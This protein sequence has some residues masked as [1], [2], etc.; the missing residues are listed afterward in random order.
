[1]IR[2]LI[3]YALNNRFIVLALGTLLLVWGAIS[4]HN[5]PV[6]AY[7]DV[8]NNYVQIITQW[9][10]RAAEEVEQQVT[11]PIETQVNGIPHLQ[12][13]RSVSLFG[14][15]SV[16]M[17]FDDVSENDW[18]RQKVLERLSQVTLPNGLQP[19][20]GTDWSP[21]GQIYWYTLKS[22]NPKYDL[23]ELKS[24]QDWVLEKQFKSVPNVVDVVG[25][26]GTTREYQVRVDPNKLVAYG[27]SIGQVE[28][29]LANNNTNA[30]GSFVEAGLQQV[31]VREVGLLKSTRDIAET[32]VK[33]QNGIAI[34]VKDIAEVTQAPKIRL[35]QIGKTIRRDNG[36][37]LDNEDVIEGIVLLR[38]GANA[39]I[40]LVAIHEKVKELNNQ[41]LPSGVKIVPFLDR[42]NLVHLTTHTVLHNLTE[43]VLLVSV[44][45]F[46]FLGN[47]R[48]AVIVALTIPFSLLFAAICLDLS[49]IPANLLSLGALDFGMVVDGT[50]VII[51][52]I[53]RHFSLPESAKKT[54]LERIRDAVR[55][56][57]RPVF[58]ARAIIIA[59][60]LP[61]FTL[62]SV[63]GRLFKPMAWTVSF[64]LVGALIF[65]ILIAP[66][67]AFLQFR[68][69]VNEWRN[70]VMQFLKD[71]YRIAVKWAIEHRHITVGVG[72]GA[73]AVAVFLLVSGVIGS[74]F[75]PH[76]D[77]G[78]IWVR[79]TL[80]PSTGPTEGVR[81]A[82]QARVILAS[83]PEVQVTTSQVGRPDD[84][85]DTTGFFNTEFFVDLK[86]KEKWRP[87]FREN[88]DKLIAA[89]DRELTKIPGV[90][91]NFSQPI[92]DNMEEAVSGV[93][94]ELAVKLYGEDLK[95]LEKKGD[96]IVNIMRGISG[97][98]DLGLFRVLGQPNLNITVDRQQAARHGINVADVQDAVETSVG[99]KAVSQ[100]L[101]NEQRFDLVVRY[102]APYRETRQAI[103]NVRLLS[104]TGER[105]SLGQFA[106]LTVRDGASEIYREENSR[107]VAI[108]YSV[109]GR[110]LGS[111][112][113]DAMKRVSDQVKLPAGYHLNWSGEYESQ[114]R[115]EKRLLVV[116]PI[117]ILGIFVILYTMFGSS[118]W[119][120]LILANVA[121]APIGGLLALLIT[122]THLS[123]SSGV[124]FL[125]L[126]GVSVE[127]GVIM[128]EY[129]NQ[130]RSAGHTIESA[131][132]E[133]AVL[134][135]RPIM[136]TMLVAT[137]GLFPAALSRAIGSD[138]QRPFAI[139]IVGGLIGALLLSIFLL[140]ALYVWFAREGDRLPE[141]EGDFLES[142]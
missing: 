13:L 9:P 36:T 123:V 131:A 133:G 109:R 97:I 30:G 23:M 125:A 83:F 92:S 3:D 129:I 141:P 100:V 108:K 68:N 118:K 114:K 49:N 84:G 120:G 134:R 72:A 37:I 89:M 25:F 53:V 73:F 90:L 40:A 86:P 14:L 42:S 46:F 39:D 110:D 1:M 111:A 10:G 4:F 33:T 6:E 60:Y 140:P 16:M 11:I 119:A 121:I 52:N 45:L 41:I 139:V 124:G 104:T 105:V 2:N 126:F 95:V 48:G 15:S 75:L 64:A 5:L 77:E 116:L 22:T 12:H 18:N 70:P 113:Q 66:V 112:V 59:A 24:I 96:E 91:W 142:A 55:E 28:Q 94:G 20:M 54:P 31:N 115:S 34:R 82:N 57:L 135:L 58:Y 62:Q 99:G 132:I 80:A 79:G 63:E 44:I 107:Y 76:L 87:I 38:K 88:K 122:G 78:A 26:G 27:L 43:G 137:L 85:T 56:V 50:V 21:V 103:E 47:F 19:Q 67:L 65:S 136:M 17:I 98:A 32:M 130:L 106:N 69:G 51:E 71:K 81:V 29:Q 101:Q 74:E 7:P 127:T 117:T 8:A 61:I 93:K 128:L 102:Q 35:G 138:S